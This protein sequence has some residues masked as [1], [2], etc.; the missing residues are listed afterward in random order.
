MRVWPYWLTAHALINGG[1]VYLATG[2]VIYGI[3]ETII[4]WFLDFLKSDNITNPHIDQFVH[5]AVKVL[6]VLE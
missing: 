4:H 3:F 6:M 2:N 5:I 1:M